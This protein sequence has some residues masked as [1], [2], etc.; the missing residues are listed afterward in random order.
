MSR[1]ESPNINTS[2]DRKSFERT[3][4][5][6]GRAMSTLAL[7]S[8]IISGAGNVAHTTGPGEDYAVIR[9]HI[10]PD[11]T[12]V[13]AET[14]ITGEQLVMRGLADPNVFVAADG[15]C[16]LSGTERARPGVPQT[17][18]LYRSENLQQWEI[19]AR[20]NP[21]PGFR[22]VWAPELTKEYLYFTAE[23]EQ[24]GQATYRAKVLEPDPEAPGSGLA[25]GSPEL[26]VGGTGPRPGGVEQA[27]D[28]EIVGNTI[29]FTRVGGGQNRISAVNLDDLNTVHDMAVPRAGDGTI[30]EAPDVFRDKNG[31]WHLIFSINDFRGSYGLKEKTATTFAGLAAPDAPVREIAA[32]T[33]G[34][35]GEIIKNIGHSSVFERNGN[36]FIVYHVGVFNEHGK[37][38]RRDTY[39]AQLKQDS[40]G[41]ILPLENHPID[42][43]KATHRGEVEVVA[44]GKEGIES[45]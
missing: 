36:Y 39:I 41:N 21:G 27:I 29:V 1:A 13:E 2:T 38:V 34:S 42:R 43:T 40:N 18:P 14:K 3:R 44:V 26:V 23:Y 6:T 32:A 11:T 20:Y 9:E 22:N 5:F 8:A 15:S 4:R 37:L 33:H 31:K 24:E 10:P 35:H 12:T 17:I 28:P 45:K 25:F 16:I 7:T 19:V 30:N